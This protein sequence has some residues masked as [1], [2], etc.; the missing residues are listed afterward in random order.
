MFLIQS[1]YIWICWVFDVCFGDCVIFMHDCLFS[2]NLIDKFLGMLKHSKI[3]LSTKLFVLNFK[4]RYTR[5][6]SKRRNIFLVLII[7]WIG[8]LPIEINSNLSTNLQTNYN[9]LRINIES[10]FSKYNFKL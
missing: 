8:I 2:Y 7:H 4:L 5:F 3:S 10:I 1:Y 6:L 9:Q